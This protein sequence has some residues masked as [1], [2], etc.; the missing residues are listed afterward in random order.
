MA[1][2]P[3][4][5]SAVDG[6]LA[7]MRRHPQLPGLGTAIVRI[8]AM[9]D[10]NV[11]SIQ[12]LRNVILADVHLTQRI[13]GIANS[14][15]YRLS[16]AARITTVTRAIVVIGFEQVKLVALG[17]LFVDQMPEQERATALKAELIQALQASLL[18]REMSRQLAPDDMEKA[19]IAALLGNVAKL[20]LVM[21][22][23]DRYR[24]ISRRVAGGATEAS[25]ADDVLGMPLK[26]LT[27]E[28]LTMW[29]IPEMLVSLSMG[30]VAPVESKKMKH[31]DRIVEL[32]RTTAQHLRHRGVA[33]REALIANVRGQCIAES[34]VSGEAFDRWVSAA[35]AQMAPVRSMLESAIP[36]TAVADDGFPQGSVIDDSAPETGQ[37]NAIGKPA[38]SHELVLSRLQDLTQLIAD[39]QSLSAILL[40]A[41]ECLHTGFGYS[42]SILLL[43]DAG[44][45]KMR[46]RVWCGAIT[47]AQASHL[48]INIDSA[49]DLFAVAV[50]RG[51]DVQIRNALAP[52][53]AARLPPYFTKAC[54]HTASFIILPI[55]SEDS[56]IACMLVG[57][58]VPEPEPIS[59]EDMRLHRTVRGQIILAMRTV[60]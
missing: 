30:T 21:I 58:D 29:G 43:R 45:P 54:P 25:A 17:M 5:T 46:A 31:L 23:F 55:M 42:R 15:G 26:T 34:G 47:K 40:T 39:R 59:P 14:V 10:S 37:L 50:R 22:D 41:L 36:E 35:D 38:N 27:S 51:T 8:L 49:G 28:V 2:V 12:E 44:T 20:L 48:E 4:S 33:E 57:R 52:T 56:P 13:I 11:E 1:D 9:V 18:A 7:A 24:E 19:G 53:I 3:R 6:L 60:R 16:S 32:A